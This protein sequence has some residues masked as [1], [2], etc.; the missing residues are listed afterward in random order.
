M[1][2]RETTVNGWSASIDIWCGC[3]ACSFCVGGTLSLV[4]CWIFTGTHVGTGLV[5][6]YN[7]MTVTLIYCMRSRLIISEK[8]NWNRQSVS[9]RNESALTLHHW[10]VYLDRVHNG[11]MSISWWLFLC[12]KSVFGLA[13]TLTFDLENLW[14]I[15]P[16]K[17][18]VNRQMDSG[19]THHGQ[20]DGR[21]DDP[22]RTAG[23]S[24]KSVWWW[25]CV[26]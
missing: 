13:V 22:Y 16:C 15:T 24:A 12:W 23:K 19:Q 7:I 3:S 14:D 2:S 8:I 17:L 26:E 10:L 25:L 11:L 9:I 5:R 21:P 20:L 6:L 18:G 1:L 4:I